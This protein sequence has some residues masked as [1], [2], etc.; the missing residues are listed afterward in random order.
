MCR[1][2]GKPTIAKSAKWT[3]PVARWP[4]AD[5]CPARRIVKSGFADLGYRLSSS[6]SIKRHIL[7]M[8]LLLQ[9]YHYWFKLDGFDKM[10][11]DS[12]KNS[13][14]LKP[15]AIYSKKKL[16]SLK[17]DIKLWTKE[18]KSRSSG[19]KLSIQN[20]L[21]EVDKIIDQGGSNEEILNRRS[22]PLKDLHDT[23][24]IEALDIA[25]K[26]KDQEGMFPPG[27]NASFIALI[28]KI[29]DAK[30]D[31]SRYLNRFSAPSRST[32]CSSRKMTWISWNKVLAS[33]KKGILEFLVSLLLIV[34]CFSNC[35][36]SR[37]S[38]WLDIIRET[39]SLLNKGIDLLAFIRKKVGNE[40]DTLF[41]DETWL[42]EKSLKYQFP[43]LYALEECKLITVA[44]KMRH[45]G[46][47]SFYRCCPRGG[48]AEYLQSLLQAR[49]TDLVLPQMLN[50]W[51]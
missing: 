51:T 4:R 18:A 14:I 25:Q 22:T 31:A 40:E 15:N 49:V 32:I 27:C 23:K 9:I 17:N 19:T 35:P 46:L 5:A 44:E 38:P 50:R 47:S 39:N 24:A 12:W 6:H 45:D 7:I 42:G 2:R 33:K 1:V 8:V 16:Q 29:Q 10:V 41:W 28:P 26:A 36:N 3:S 30:V 21:F 37:R 20:K 13:T 11:K 34:R 43:R 48:A